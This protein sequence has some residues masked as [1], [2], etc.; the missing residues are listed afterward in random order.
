MLRYSCFVFILLCESM[1]NVYQ[2]VNKN[3]WR[4]AAVIIGF[5]AF[6]SAV[7]WAVGQYTGSGQNY[8]IPALAFSSL[9][10]IGSYWFADKIILSVSRA[11]K[12]NTIEEKTYIQVAENIARVAGIPTPRLYVIDD[13]APNAFA[14]G[15][16]PKNAIVCVTTGLLSKLNRTELE[17]VVAHEISHIIHFDTRLM[18]V[19]TVLIGSVAML[20][21]WLIRLSWGRSNNNRRDSS[22]IL[23]ILGLLLIILSPII[24]QLIQLA[25]SRQ[26]E[27][28]ADAGSAMLTRQ[29][30]GLISALQKISAD[31]EPLEVANKATANLYIINPFKSNI[32]NQSLGKMANLFNTHPPVADRIK[33]L[34]SML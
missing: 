33:E 4:S 20:S 15:R 16:D 18:M 11:R 24:G 19:V 10:G 28:Y 9:T 21:D 2:Q 27:F 8:F 17:G 3:K 32:T 29:P 26:R 12:P 25:L 5:V 14:T 23:G 6:L 30:S 22:G 1:L 31:T 13:S 34:G 7:L